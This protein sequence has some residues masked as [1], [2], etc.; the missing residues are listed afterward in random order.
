MIFFTR[1]IFKHWF[2]QNRGGTTMNPKAILYMEA[3]LI[4]VFTA[5]AT[6]QTNFWGQTNGPFGGEIIAL[7]INSEEGQIFAGKGNE[8][9]TNPPG[10][11]LQ[12]ISVRGVTENVLPI[13]VDP[14]LVTGHTYEITFLAGTVFNQL[15]W[16]L[17]D[18]TVGV[19]KLDSIPAATDTSTSHPVVDGIEWRV[20]HIPPDFANFLTVAN[21]A[22]PLD[23]PE[24]AA[25][26][27]NAS[28]F[29]HPTTGDRPTDRQQVG[30]GLWGIHTADLGFGF[31][32]E[33]F[34]QRIT[35]FGR[36]WWEII[37]YDFEIRFADSSY[38]WDAFT[39]R[40]FV[41]VPFELWNIGIDTPD[42]PIDDYRMVPWI[43]D[44]DSS[45]TF[46]MGAPNAKMFGTYDHSISGGANDPYTDW[47]YWFRPQDTTP[48]QTG[49]LA[50]EAEMIA[51]TYDGSRETEV[52]ARIVLVNWNGDIGPTP[53]S[54]IYN[55]DLPEKGTIFRIITA[56]SKSNFPGD[57]L[58]IISPSPVAPTAPTLAEPA[59][60]A[61]NQ[62]TTLMLSWSA[63]RGAEIYRLQ[64]STSSDF[65]TTV[66]DDSTITTTSLQVGPLAHNTTYYWRVRAKNIGGTS[67]YSEIW[68]FTVIV[69]LPSQV[70]LLSPT[71]AAVI[72]GDSVQFTWRQSQPAISQ[73]WFEIAAD[74]AM[75]NPVID[76]TLTAADTTKMVR[77]LLEQTYWWRVRAGNVAGWGPFSGQRRFRIDIP[78]IVQT[79]DEI[80][81]QF[82]LSQ[83]YPN[84]FNPSTTIEY[85][86]PK[87]SHVELKVYDVFGNEVRTLV[88]GKQLAGK[89]WMQFDGKGL[90]SGVYFY[91]I[92]AG[93][94]VQIKKLMLLK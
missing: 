64:V 85:T 37:P 81:R 65:A 66:V 90:P 31:S 46:N 54:G 50:A 48:G 63:S 74:S 11:T 39:T 38:A 47:I 6:T 20:F 42:D 93:A 94:F 34:L 26:A 2:F 27:F 84:P 68:R 28:G 53:P 4:A 22:G 52:M 44:D 17:T 60:G 30:A 78:T 80:P 36:N 56:K 24:Y 71:H 89:Y 91:R 55:Q 8:V 92:E 45:G 12:V 72:Q 21:A 10:D 86:L 75:A 40:N 77:Q 59:D 16:R 25:F 76:S 58:L 83:N 1:F 32:Y 49:Y 23:P 18:Q 61:V 57:A 88:K 70:S 14:F 73:Y 5:T 62:P 13:V 19:T 69:Q 41:R 82:S 33:T 9:F 67:A 79:A 29:P 43:I 15:L 51:G 3:I 7:V 35:R 87:P